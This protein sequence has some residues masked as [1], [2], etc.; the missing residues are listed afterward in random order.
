M[1]VVA[2]STLRNFWS[3]HKDCEQQLKSWYHENQSADW[4]SPSALKRDYPSA[5]IL[6]NDRIVFNIKGN[7]YRLVVK[8]NFKFQMMWIRFIGTHAEYDKINAETI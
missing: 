2:K 1:R 4:K 5:S 8:L 3:K 6:S 7:K